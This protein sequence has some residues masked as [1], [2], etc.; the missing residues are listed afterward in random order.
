MIPKEKVLKL[1][2][3]YTPICRLNNE[4]LKYLS[5][6]YTN[7]NEPKFTD[8]EIMTVYIFVIQQ[9]QRFSVKQ[10][11]DFT[12]H[13]LRSR[14]PVT[15][16]ILKLQGIHIKCTPDRNRLFSHIYKVHISIIVRSWNNKR[17]SKPALFRT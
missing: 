3:I 7:N 14:F 9:Q 8:Q 16:S 5:L 2:A 11:Y 10:I 12:N 15:H 4:D 6:R 1:I 17:S 13:Y